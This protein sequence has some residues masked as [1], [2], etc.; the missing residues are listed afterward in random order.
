MSLLSRRFRLQ[1]QQPRI[2]IVGGGFAGLSAARR[3]AHKDVNVTLIS[4]HPHAEW[5]PNVHELVSRRKSP[6]QLQL[7]LEEQLG[8]WK[9]HFVCATVTEIDHA[10][11]RLRTA[12]GTRYDYDVLILASGSQAHSHGASG[13]YEHALI[14]RSVESSFRLGNALTR[15]AALP[16]NRS[17]VIAGAGIEGLEIL[18]EI[19]RRFGDTGHLDIH[20][21]DPQNQLF[22][23]FPGLHE[24]LHTAMR[25]QVTLHLGRSITAVEAN[26][27]K[28]D[29]GSHLPS[30]FTV[31][32]AG[33]KACEL[34][35][36][37]GL[38][39]ADQ[40]ATVLPTLQ[41]LNDPYIFIA[42]DTAEL[43]PPLA[44]QAYHAQ[45]MG[46]HA[47]DNALRLL[48]GKAPLPFKPWLRPILMSFGERDGVMFYGQQALASA[49][50]LALKEGIYRVGFQQWQQVPG[51]LGLLPMAKTLRAGLTEL[52]AW[53]L[54]LQSADSRL[55]QQKP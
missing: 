41:S 3:L 8:H 24:R 27:V 17:I 31:W 52:E 19:L 28:L 21:V 29:D 14:P 4:Q 13:V 23:D 50:V 37:C 51:T 26:K 18:G 6:A 7:D 12:N 47:A 44:K 35:G 46:K 16:G 45:D 9:Q 33:R 42:G 43:S 1:R 15:L 40:D 38:A 55:F 34:V 2:V 53:R 32:S 48:Q 11:Q 10:Q 49:G 36:I 54:L 25:G 20:L 22:P 30:R 5:L 39:K